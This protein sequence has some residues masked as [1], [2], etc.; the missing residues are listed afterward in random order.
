MF[1]T[2]CTRGSHMRV[3]KESGQG[4]LVEWSQPVVTNMF[5]K[6]YFFVLNKPF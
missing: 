2:S 1:G 6:L 3:V 5:V 4:F